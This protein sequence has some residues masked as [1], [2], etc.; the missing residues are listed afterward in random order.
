MSFRN[1][2]QSGWLKPHRSSRQEI[3]D[4]FGVADRDIAACQTAGLIAD[5]RLNIAY[6]AGLQLATAALAAAGYEAAR[7]G[8]HYRVI[9]S[10]TLTLKIDAGTVAEFDDCRKLRNLADYERAG[11]ISDTEA[12]GMLELALRLRREVEAWV[13]A[14]HPALV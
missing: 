6:N 9:Q 12:D 8:H 3:A 5:W 4:L 1:W 7:V 2:V 14:N 10:L 11:Q 13:H